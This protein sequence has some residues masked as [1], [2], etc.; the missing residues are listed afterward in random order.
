MFSIQAPE[1]FNFNNPDQWPNWS[2]RFERY[3]LASKLTNEEEK[4]QVN[5]LMYLLGDKA[6]DILT[7]F[8]LSEEDSAKYKVVKTKFDEYFEVRTNV[9]YERVLFNKRV[10]L[11]NEPVDEFILALN[12]LVE[13]CNFGALKE[14]MIHDR[15]VVGLAN[16]V[17][18]ERL[19]LDPE[20]TLQKA[21]ERARNSEL[22]KKQQGTIRGAKKS[23]QVEAVKDKRRSRPM[24]KDYNGCSWCGSKTAHDKSRCPANNN[25]CFNCGKLGHFKKVCRSRVVKAIESRNEDGFSDTSVDGCF[26]NIRA[27]DHFLGTVSNNNF[28]AN[29]PMIDMFVNGIKIKFRIDTGAEITAVSKN[30]F[31]SIKSTQLLTSQQILIGP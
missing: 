25:R 9:I 28:D 20:L 11:P 17:L 13:H 30:I 26:S 24:N 15:L 21:I 29:K 12:C 1:Q 3:R 19:Q 18:T 16:L 10:Q 6:D 27:G 2:R 4:N 23:F 14:E 31:N 7:S 5:T 22:V 8:Q